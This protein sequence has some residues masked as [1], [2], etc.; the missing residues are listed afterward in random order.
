MLELWV[1]RHLWIIFALH[2]EEYEI[3][4]RIIVYVYYTLHADQ[5]SNMRR[6]FFLYLLVHRRRRREGAGARTP[7]PQIGQ[8]SCKIRAFCQFLLLVWDQCKKYLGGL[9]TAERPTDD[10]PTSHLGK[11]QMAISPQG[12]NQPIHFMFVSKV[13]FSGS[14]DHMA[15]FWLGRNSIRRL[16]GRKQCAKS[17]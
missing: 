15:L 7:P 3:S 2:E 9:L 5:T 6:V 12:V 1:W 8:L 10:R 13:V 16:F 11:F 17:N 4:V 14:A